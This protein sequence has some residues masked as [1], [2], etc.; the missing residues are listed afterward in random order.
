MPSRQ[1]HTFPAITGTLSSATIITA[2][3]VSCGALCSVSLAMFL[4]MPSGTI[5]CSWWSCAASLGGAFCTARIIITHN[6]AYYQHVHTIPQTPIIGLPKTLRKPATPHN[7]QRLCD[8][9]LYGGGVAVSVAAS[10]FWSIVIA[11]WLSQHPSTMVSGVA[12]SSA[13]YC[14]VLHTVVLH[15]VFVIHSQ[16]QGYVWRLLWL[17]L[18]P[19]SY[20]LLTRHIIRGLE[21]TSAEIARLRGVMYEHHKA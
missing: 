14:D 18:C 15:T 13:G 9:L 4:G 10:M 3:M 1:Q 20:A 11:V 7:R 8:Q 19:V 2:E 21:D 12:A 6:H 5:L 16:T 17:P